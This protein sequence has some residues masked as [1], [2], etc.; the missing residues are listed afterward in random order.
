MFNRFRIKKVARDYKINFHSRMGL[1]VNGLLVDNFD[2]LL[3]CYSNSQVKSFS[4]REHLFIHHLEIIEEINN[5]LKN[6]KL[7]EELIYPV[8]ICRNLAKSKLFDL[9]KI[10]IALVEYYKVEAKLVNKKY[11]LK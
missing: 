1:S 10:I 9:K 2:Y 7:R 5:D 3:S 11:L 8:S 6:E 4:N